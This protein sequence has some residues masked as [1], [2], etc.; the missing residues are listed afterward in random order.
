MKILP[1]I[2]LYAF[3]LWSV[4][5]QLGYLLFQVLGEWG[6]V[7]QNQ[8]VL[9]IPN[10]LAELGGSEV[11]LVAHNARNLGVAE[12]HSSHKCVFILLIWMN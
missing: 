2:L 12:Y 3:G 1:C 7:I 6:L 4:F 8:T 10:I 11:S 5:C 9:T